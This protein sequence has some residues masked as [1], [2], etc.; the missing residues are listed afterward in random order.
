MADSVFT[1]DEAKALFKEK[2]PTLSLIHWNIRS[3]RKHHDD[4]IALLCSLDH[5]FSFVCLSETWLSS[6]DGNLYGLS[7][8][9]SEY[10][11]REGYRSGGSAILV[12]SSLSYKRRHDLFFSSLSL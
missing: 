1:F 2:Q 8:Y 3:V 10:C 11:H 4:F 12:K 9:T 5:A 7:G 6:H